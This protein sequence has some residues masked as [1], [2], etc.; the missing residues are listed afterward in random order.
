MICSC[1]LLAVSDGD[2]YE[3]DIHEVFA[4][5]ASGQP[6]K[7][8]ICGTSSSSAPASGAVTLT[9]NGA[10]LDAV[11][12]H[13]LVPGQLMQTWLLLEP[14][15]IEVRGDTLFP[16]EETQ[17]IE[18]NADQ[19]DVTRFEPRITIGQH[20]YTWSLL[21]N[22]LGIIDLTQVDE[23]WYLITYAWAQI[24]MPEE[25]QAVLGIGSDDAVKVWLNG[26]L[27]H[28]NRISRGVNYDNDRVPV[29]FKKGLNQL[30][31][32]IQNAGGSWGFCCRMLEE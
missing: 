26:E 19:I 20:T 9:Q 31:L 6:D 2:Y 5:P 23:N 29:T 30:V 7:W 32:K 18:F 3:V 28:E 22:D 12:Y 25:K 27:I 4:R 11:T 17:K 21:Q 8:V 13:E 16:S 14:I 1:K 10:N 24:E 15:R